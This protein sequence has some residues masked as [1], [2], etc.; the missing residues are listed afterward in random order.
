MNV[1]LIK[2][3]T[4]KLSSIH[5]VI[6]FTQF[7]NQPSVAVHAEP[8]GNTYNQ[9]SE[10]NGMTETEDGEFPRFRRVPT[11]TLLNNQEVNGNQ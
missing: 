10:A 3:M 4:H 9:S 5:S 8:K 7:V 11:L 1:N 6:F 2:S